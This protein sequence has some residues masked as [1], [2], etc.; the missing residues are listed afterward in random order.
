MSEATQ[1]SLSSNR[2]KRGVVRASIT[3]LGS[4]VTELEAATSLPDT[5]DRARRFTTRLESLAEEFK[6]HHFAV[7]D[8]LDEEEDLAREQETFDEQDEDVTQLAL[9]LERIV[10]SCPSSDPNQCKMASGRLKHLEKRLSSILGNVTS[11]PVDGDICLLQ[12]FDAQLSD[13]KKEFSDIHRGLL[14]LDVDD[15]SDL[16]QSLAHVEKAIFDCGLEIPRLL[17]SR[18]SASPSSS[19]SD[20]TGVKL[21]K[22]DVP[23]FDGSILNWKTF[24][25][26]FSVAVHDR[27]NLTHSEKLAYLR[28][29]LKAGSA[30]SVIEGLSRSGEQY[31]EAITC[32]KSRYDRP[33]LIHQAH[34]RKILE[35]PNLKDGS[36][37][38]L[39]RLHDTALQHLRALKSMGHEPSGPFITSM[40]ELKLDA[41]TMFEWQR[42]SQS[43]PDVPHYKLLLEFIDLRAQASE[44]AVSDPTKKSFKIDPPSAKKNFKSVASFAASA[45]PSPGNCVVCKSEKH[46]LYV[47]SQ[48]RAL[49]HAAK[50]SVLKTNSL[51]LNCLR[52]G[53]F[54]SSCKS[55]HKCRVCQK[56]HHSL[57]HLEGRGSIPDARPTVA[58]SEVSVSTASSFPIAAVP[59]STPISTHA[60]VG[61]KSDL[62]LMTCRVLVESHDGSVMEARAILDSGSS[63]SFVSERLAQCLQLPRFSQNTR[64]TGVAGIV[65]NSAQ[66][67]TA[68]QVSSVH[69]PTKMFAVTAVVVPHV[70]SD[71]PLQP[72]PMDL[73]WDHLSDLQ[74]ADPNFGQPGKIDLLLGVEIFVEVMLH[75]RRCGIPG[76]PVAFETQFGWV[77]AGST[78]FGAP[79]QV[80]TTHHAMLLTGDDLLRSFW[81]V[82][83]IPAMECLTTDESA[84]VNHF[85]KHH[86]RLENGRFLVPLPKKAGMKPLGESR[87]QAVRRFLTFE[88]SLHSKGLF[89]EFKPVIDEY[90]TMGHAEPVPAVDL[91]KPP[92]SVFYLPMQAVKKPSSTTTKVR[93]VFDASAR[94]STGISLN[95]TLLVGPTVHSSLVD[96][97]LRF[98][99]HRVALIADVSRMYR[100]IALTPSDRDLHRFVWRDSPNVPLKDFRM[101]R[102]TFGVSASSFIANMSV[103][104]N[105]LD[106]ALAYPLAAKAVE[107]SFYVDD[108]LTGADSIEGAIELHAQLQTLFDKGGFLLR[109]WNSS[110]PAV[111]QQIAAELRDQQSVRTMSE[112]DEYTKTLGVDWNAKLDHF[113]LTVAELSHQ[114]HWTK[115]ALSSDIAKTF[116]VLGWFAPVIIKAKIFLQ[117]LW[118]EGLGWDDPVPATLEQ[119]WLEW[120]Q[121]LCLLVDKH[122]PRC[123][124][125]KTVKIAYRQLHGFSDASEGAYAGAVYFRF[126]DTTGCVHTSLVMA[127]TKVAP[128]KRLSIPRLELCGALLLAQLLHHCQAIFDLP[129]EDV[130]AW[131]DSTI[132]LNWLVGNPRR[133]KTFVGSRVSLISDLVAPSRWSH[134]EGSN[135]PADCASRGLLPSELLSHG[136]WW[137]GPSWLRMGIHC[138]PKTATLMS[139][140]PS[141]EVNEICSRAAV[142][143]TE[144]VFP[145]DR[146]SNFTRLKRVTAWMLRFVSNCQAR[147]KKLVRM[148]GPLTV[149]EL[150]KAVTYWVSLSQFAHF[151]A[152]I[153]A[154][155]SPASLP[156]SST[157]LSL[158]PFLDEVGLLRVGGRQQNS[159]LTYDR[160]HL[161]ILHGKHPVSKLLVHTEHLRLLHAGPLLVAASLGRH[162]YIMGGRKT[163]RSITRSC[164][165]CRR[166]SLR[167]QPPLMGQ[168]PAERVTPDMV[169]DRVGVDYAGP[170][171][172]KYGSV[173]KPTLVKAYVC[174]FVSLSVK[175]VHLELVSDLTTEAFV[176]CLRRFI[177]R[178]GKPSLIWSDHGSNF[179]GA[180][181]HL[182]ELIEFLQQ[183]QSQEVISNFCSAQNIVWKFIPGRAPHFG[184]LWEAAVK[185]FKKHLSCVVGEVKL[186]FE[187]LT[188]VLAQIESCLNSRPLTALPCVEDGGVG[189]LTPGHF[190]IGRPLE[191]LPDP[192]VSY[193]PLTLLKR[194]HLCQALVRHFWKRWSTEYLAGLQRMNKWRTP[195]PSKISVGDI[196]V[197]RADETIP[198]Q[199]PLAK[200]L[201]THPGKDGVVRVVTIKT[202]RGNVYTSPVVKTALLLP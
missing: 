110:E 189:A 174:V 200:V 43:S 128:I 105:A 94:T 123:Y 137:N 65:S 114:D 21:P 31:D 80:A 3:K 190:L 113:R 4:R 124:Y 55:L 25:E 165:I 141:D 198:G 87:S 151:A 111:L 61:I 163:V 52:P 184:G 47:C 66:H 28:H 197:I 34:V 85:E 82:E 153:V 157:L 1:R 11:F 125:P 8:L 68:F 41:N 79:A 38:E 199:W 16:G 147:Q 168:L 145:L 101:T 194:W 36:G 14:S 20:T 191:A 35:V 7:I 122:I 50:L 185:S 89:P 132:V 64:I 149:R 115:R 181:R 136:L 202:G 72:I 5:V 70:T 96:V 120:R 154:V 167:P 2:K 48:F 63:A 196:V 12:Q 138:W 143:R 192:A 183:Q 45:N 107:E 166:K 97:L 161:I 91:E 104:R 187:E 57:L 54:V 71:L 92:H 93:A 106:H 146:F 84:A 74:L 126:V 162:F 51:C 182:K 67:I 37:R 135:N 127:K 109:K 139:N 121:E 60:A 130:F 83:R 201:Q 116:D 140:D 78:G 6:H 186:T 44:A 86:T 9:G 77:L 170:I 98:R 164:I 112:H 76:S 177:A 42:H 100:A 49:D 176:A 180:S 173:R 99:L 69:H 24:W 59:A 33:R 134:V 156:K 73:R 129:T 188:T 13:Y 75:G 179:V 62:L 56:P 10:S 27:S 155:K 29:A 178:R 150:N 58:T 23:T 148:S 18:S 95:D 169:F 158:N 88:R 102:V 118:E 40:L 22:L 26:Q 160:Q 32:L 195:A 53:H 103:R 90:F 159:K 144:P 19:V 193:Q 119:A 171:Y 108:G 172:V 175:A 17:H 39:R 81:E 30:K 142:V 131:T 117:R 46:P 152:E 15:T 133:F